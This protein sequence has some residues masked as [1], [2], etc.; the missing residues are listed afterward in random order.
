MA[1]NPAGHVRGPDGGSERGESVYTDSRVCGCG[2]LIPLPPAGTRGMRR[3][4]CG[5]CRA[6]RRALTFTRQAS[7]I[8]EQ[9][10]DPQ[11]MGADG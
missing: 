7:R 3:R 6:T 2:R 11:W 10:R 8:L 5:R 1:L 4:F 9:L